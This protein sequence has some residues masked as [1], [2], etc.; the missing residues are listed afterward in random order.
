MQ[1]S[2][3]ALPPKLEAPRLLTRDAFGYGERW[4]GPVCVCV[5]RGGGW[6]ERHLGGLRTLTALLGA[7]SH[8]ES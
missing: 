4:N 6:E 2:G 1:E 5:L 3:S 8:F 7:S